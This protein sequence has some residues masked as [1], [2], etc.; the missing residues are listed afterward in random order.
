MLAHSGIPLPVSGNCCG[1]FP[2]IR[3]SSVQ[4]NTTIDSNSIDSGNLPHVA[5]GAGLVFDKRVALKQLGLLTITLVI[6][7]TISK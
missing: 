3:L 6:S 5:L 2:A 4:S 7:H 1:Q